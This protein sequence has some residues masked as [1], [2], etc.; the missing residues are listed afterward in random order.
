M[1]ASSGDSGAVVKRTTSV[2]IRPT[3]STSTLKRGYTIAGTRHKATCG[4]GSDSTSDVDFS[5]GHHVYLLDEP[6]RTNQVWTEAS[7]IWK[8]DH[9]IRGLRLKLT[10][11]WFPG[12]NPS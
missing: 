7:V 6:D 12:R 2:T 5:C 8:H 1:T 9:Y 11:A 3:T 4:A 10:V